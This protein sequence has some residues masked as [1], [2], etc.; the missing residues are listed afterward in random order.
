MVITVK[1]YVKAD[2]K[3]LCS[4]PILLD[5]YILFH[6]FCRQLK[7][8]KHCSRKQLFIKIIIGSHFHKSKIITKECVPLTISYHLCFFRVFKVWS[9]LYRGSEGRV[10]KKGC[11]LMFWCTFLSLFSCFHH[12][13]FVFIICIF[14]VFLTKYQISATEFLTSQWKNRF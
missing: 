2:I 11:Y 9:M 1:N 4:C 3:V 14:F 5:S 8:K 7:E 13:I 10:L 12:K 6:I